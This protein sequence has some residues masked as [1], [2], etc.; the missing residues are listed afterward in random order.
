MNQDIIP[1]LLAILLK[2]SV[3]SLISYDE[4]RLKGDENYQD[5]S[6][7]E[8]FVILIRIRDAQNVSKCNATNIKVKVF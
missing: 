8:L 5:C 4:P 3:W 7:S 6:H 1:M 2:S